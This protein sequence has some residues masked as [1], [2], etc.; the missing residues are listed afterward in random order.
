MS[1]LASTFAAVV[2]YVVIRVVDPY[3]LHLAPDPEICS[4]MDPDTRVVSHG[5]VINFENS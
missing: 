3:S 5:Y 1:N 4:D 2:T